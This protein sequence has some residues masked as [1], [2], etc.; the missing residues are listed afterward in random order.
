MNLRT[1]YAFKKFFGTVEHVDLLKRFL[2]SIFSGRMVI[3]DITFHDKEVL[4][5]DPKG[6]KIVYDI[7]CTTTTG[8]HFIVEMQNINKPYYYDRVVF[9]SA[10]A[11]SE[12][13]KSGSSY[14][15]Q[16]LYAIFVT[17]FEI[18]HLTHGMT[19]EI[20]L[21]DKDTGELF[22]DKLNIILL[23]LTTAK[24]TWEECVNEYDHIVYLIK[25][26]HTMDKN[27]KAYKSGE[28]DDFFKAGELNNMLEEEVATYNQSYAAMVEDELAIQEVNDNWIR[29][30]YEVGI[31]L[32]KIVEASKLP[33]EEIKRVL[34]ID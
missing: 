16:P 20:C 10:K 23:P 5:S 28:Y 9:Y 11:L 31:P 18:K 29:S 2:N 34:N 15:L 8:K 4:P 27:S 24:A 25:N 21:I 7:Y 33:E 22:S 30:L 17:N 26:M 12:Q 3:D 19:H 1:D 6:K 13:L 14:K 32:S